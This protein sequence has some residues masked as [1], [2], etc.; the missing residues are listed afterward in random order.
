M[1]RRCLLGT[2]ALVAAG[3]L[4]NAQQPTTP[5]P[6]PAPVVHVAT[7]LAFPPVIDRAN[8]F[9]SIDYSTVGRPDAGYAWKYRVADR[10]FA[11]IFIYARLRGTIADGSDDPVVRLA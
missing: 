4:A 3:T 10:M 1:I 8:K 7:G 6:M 5:L 11:S 9:E 2:I